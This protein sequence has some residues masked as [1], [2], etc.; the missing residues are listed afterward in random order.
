MHM[1]TRTHTHSSSSSL[2]LVHMDVGQDPNSLPRHRFGL[3]VD[4]GWWIASRHTSLSVTT[5]CQF[6]IPRM[7]WLMRSTHR[8]QVPPGLLF[9][10]LGLHLRSCLCGRWGGILCRCPNHWSLFSLSCSLIGSSPVSSSMSSLRRM[11]HRVTPTMSRRHLSVL[12]VHR[13]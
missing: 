2:R 10:P 8:K 12:F 4:L 5:S 13:N 11:S 3:G 9:F 6:G 7:S 1:C